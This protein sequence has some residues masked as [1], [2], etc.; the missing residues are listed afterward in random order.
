MIKLSITTASTT[1]K[2]PECNGQQVVELVLT[3][4]EAI[5][6]FVKATFIMCIGMFVLVQ[7]LL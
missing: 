3:T 7:I 1:M 4:A 5:L 2:E 6:L